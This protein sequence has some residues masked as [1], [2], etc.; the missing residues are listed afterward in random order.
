MLQNLPENQRHRVH[1][2]VRPAVATDS[3]QCLDCLDRVH[4][5]AERVGQKLGGGV[6]DGRAAMSRLVEPD[7]GLERETVGIDGDSDVDLAARVRICM[8]TLGRAAGRGFFIR[9]TSLLLP[10]AGRLRASRWIIVR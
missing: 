9:S 5:G 4:T 3:P 7:E 6:E 8:V 10:G 1:A 2:A